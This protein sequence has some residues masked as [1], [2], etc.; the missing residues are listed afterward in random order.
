MAHSDAERPN[1]A[2]NAEWNGATAERWLE[3]HEALDRQIAVF[4]RR[5]MDRVAI[6]P[7]QRILDIGC[8]AGK[9]T[10]DLARRVGDAGFVTGVDVSRQLLDVARQLAR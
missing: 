6:R 7:G 3:R 2:Q 1:V 10:L 9:T 5:A 8:G 4:G